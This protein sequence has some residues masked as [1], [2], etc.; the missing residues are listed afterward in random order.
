M[1]NLGKQWFFTNHLCLDIF[2]GIGLGEKQIN[3]AKEY[4]NIYYSDM[5]DLKIGFFAGSNNKIDLCTQFGLKF[6]YL[7][8]WKK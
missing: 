7:L 4:S 6:G 5:E 1:L 3:V 2:A 8:D